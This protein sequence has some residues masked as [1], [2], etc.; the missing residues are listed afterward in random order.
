MDAKTRDIVIA[1]VAVAV[2]LLLVW[3]YKER[4]GAGSGSGAAGSKSG[5]CGGAPTPGAESEAYGLYQLGFRPGPSGQDSVP[6]GPVLVAAPAKKKST[7]SSAPPPCAVAS[8]GCGAPVAPE[9]LA[10][11]QALQLAG[12]LGPGAPGYNAAIV[13]ELSAAG[14]QRAALLKAAWAASDEGAKATPQLQLL[15][16]ETDAQYDNDLA[17]FDILQ[18][19]GDNSLADVILWLTV[20]RPFA[21]QVLALWTAGNGGASL[22][23]AQASWL[24]NPVVYAQVQSLSEALSDRGLFNPFGPIYKWAT[25]HL[26]PQKSGFACGQPS[27]E[28]AGEAYMLG[29]L[30]ALPG[31]GSG[32]SV[33]AS[34]ARFAS[35]S[36]GFEGAIP[37]SGYAG[38]DGLI[39]SRAGA[40]S[41]CTNA[42][43]SACAVSCGQRTASV[44]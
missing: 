10:E 41:A 27:Q 20:N 30:Q 42:C 23:A 11:A 33:P 2:I 24:T 8:L 13:V 34:R 5:M 14:Q 32:P 12:G 22:T 43:G 38:G 3:V 40:Y 44:F 9:A 31:D 36:E 19:Q 17:L 7:F 35:V 21:K 1:V 18:S 28:A 6:L 39:P 37:V 16:G 4:S 29:A 15:V 26:P 25:A